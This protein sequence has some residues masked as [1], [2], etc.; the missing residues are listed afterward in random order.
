MVNYPDIQEKIMTLKEAVQRFIKS[1]SQIALG[2]FT[3]SRNPMAIAYE[4][5]RQSIK[6]LHIVCHSQGQ[7]FDI[8]VGHATDYTP[9]PL[10]EIARRYASQ[11][12]PA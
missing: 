11:S 1:G 4:I 7:S 3:I 10:A 5:V 2:G 6:D 8:L 12:V 9:V